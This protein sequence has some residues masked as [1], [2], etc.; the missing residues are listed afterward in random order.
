[1]IPKSK[2]EL[3]ESLVN[4]I[5]QTLAKEEPV[6]EIVTEKPKRDR[7]GQINFSVP[8]SVKESWKILCVKNHVNLKQGMTFAMEHL[9][10]E[11]EDGEAVLTVAGVVKKRQ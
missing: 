7:Q 10:H 2:T 8:E 4:Q 9:I 5:S 11:I 3:P 6:E 1:M